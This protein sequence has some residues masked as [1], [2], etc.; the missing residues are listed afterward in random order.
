M[1]MRPSLRARFARLALALGLAFS[2]VLPAATPASAADKLV[3]RIGTT[4]DLTSLNPWN[5]SLVVDYEVFQINY[6]LLVGFGNDLSPVPGFA[7]SWSPSADGKMWTFK[8]RPGMKWSDGQPATSEDARW[9]IQIALDADKNGGGVVGLGYISAYFVSSGISSVSAPDPETLVITTRYATQRVLAMD[10]P[11]LPKHIWGKETLKTIGD[12]KNDVPVVGTGPYQAVEWKTGQYVRFVR[13]PNYWGSRGAEDEI[14]IRFFP[15]A[16]DTMV[17]AF[18]RGELDYV[19]NPS[20]Q[21]FDQLKTQPGIVA[22]DSPSTGFDELGFNTYGKNIPGGGASTKALRDPLFRDALGYAIDKPMLVDKVL[23]G[24]G[25]AGTTMVPPFYVQYHVEPTTPR[26]FDMALAKQKLEAAGY[27]LNASG[28]RLDKEGKPLNLR[29][30]FPNSDPSYAAYAQFITDWFGQ[31]GIKVK[32]QAFDGGTLTTIELPPEAS[33]PGKANYDLFIWGWVGDTGDPNILLQPF[34]TSSIGSQSDSQYSNP[35]Y[36]TLYTQQNEA[37]TV[38]ARKGPM[39]EMQQIIYNDA[40]YHILTN[41]SELHLYRT[42]KFANWQ[43]MP[44]QTG[45]PF[46]VMG[47]LNYTVLTD[48]SAVPSPAP[49]AS[50]SAGPAPSSGASAG[51]TAPP[52]SGGGGAGGASTTLIAGIVVLVVIL[53]GGMVLWRRRIGGGPGGRGED[54]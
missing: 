40:P 33:P 29:L 2:A 24:H 28:A 53:A 14:V 11:I 9:T 54:E 44:P 16:Q 52:A 20:P 22:L 8:I 19:R 36:D 15:D 48:A 7:E 21:Q 17:A 49:S 41:G 13:N 43:L 46:F 6:D 39:A 31:L 18:K 23:H 32:G 51:P 4:Q 47:N 10:A 30:Y 50:G 37:P 45:T 12:F 27:V 3:L 5:A 38:D 34:L 25:T 35:R 42:D 26:T 1:T